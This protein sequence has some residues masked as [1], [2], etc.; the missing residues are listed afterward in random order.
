LHGGVIHP[1]DTGV[2]K[3]KVFKVYVIT[4]SDRASQG[5][6]KDLSGPKISEM[7][8]KFFSSKKRQSNIENTLIPDD[9]QL[10][11]QLVAQ[12]I[13]KYDIIITTGGTGIGPK[14]FT[15]DIVKSLLEK[16]IRALWI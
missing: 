16:E 1:E 12:A 11:E 4:L 13:N 6:Y 14:D 9:A 15:P 10:L 5:V 8:E 7:A 2:Y 3:P